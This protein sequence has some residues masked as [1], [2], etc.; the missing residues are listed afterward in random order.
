MPRADDDELPGDVDPTKLE[1]DDADHALIAEVRALPV[2]G[3]EPDWRTLE[4]QIRAQVAPLAMPAPWWRN[5]RWLVP[6]GALAAT[7]GVVLVLATRHEGA[8]TASV[9]AALRDA[10]IAA[11]PAEAPSAPNDDVAAR[12]PSLWLDGE[13][14]DLDDS[15]DVEDIG[16]ADADELLDVEA[17]SGDGHDSVSSML[18]TVDDSW[19]D[20]LD[21]DAAAR[22]EQFLARKRS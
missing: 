2:E 19:I 3:E 1:L 10:S 18:P 20:S 16:D 6:I 9:Q 14:I 17:L 5:W 4:A 11:E 8:P 13:V 22:L 21:D 15:S 12:A 7:A